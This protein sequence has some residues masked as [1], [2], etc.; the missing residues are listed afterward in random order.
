MVVRSF[1][2]VCSLAARPT[3]S[4]ASRAFSRATAACRSRRNAPVMTFASTV[5]APNGFAT[6]KVRARPC[7]QMSCGLKPT[8]SRPKADTEP[9]SGR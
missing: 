4:I 8:I 6:W 1:A 2:A 9:V 7:A 3:N 5:I